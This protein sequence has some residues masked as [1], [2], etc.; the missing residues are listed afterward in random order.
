LLTR[1]DNYQ[2]DESRVIVAEMNY[3]QV[4]NALRYDILD[5]STDGKVKKMV[6]MGYISAKA[7][8]GKDREKARGQLKLPPALCQIQS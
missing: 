1:S 8:S 2:K 4:C 5:P 6:E 3:M 7:L